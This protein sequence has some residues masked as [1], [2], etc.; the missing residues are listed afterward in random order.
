MRWSGS[1][2]TARSRQSCP[3]ASRQIGHESVAV[4]YNA[5]MRAAETHH[6][7]EEVP[8][9]LL[10][11]R[12]ARVAFDADQE[13]TLKVG[14]FVQVDEEAVDL[15]LREDVARLQLPLVVLL[16]DKAKS[17]PILCKPR[18]RRTASAAPATPRDPAC[19]C[20]PNRESR[21]RPATVHRRGRVAERQPASLRLAGEGLPATREDPAVS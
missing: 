20:A 8:E 15:I 12:Q 9:A 21:A 2:S 1:R 4:R 19:T 5:C 16:I 10:L 11:R 17:M 6:L 18:A 13:T 14:E 3:P 7:E